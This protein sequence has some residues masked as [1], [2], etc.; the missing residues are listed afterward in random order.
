MFV[1][2][3]HDIFREGE[4]KPYA[5]TWVMYFLLGWY[6]ASTFK[7]FANYDRAVVFQMIA[8]MGVAF[9]VF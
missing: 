4:F 3:G 1:F 7:T 5:L 9:E 8:F 2:I 6:F